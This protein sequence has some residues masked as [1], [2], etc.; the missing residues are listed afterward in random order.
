MCEGPSEGSPPACGGHPC[1]SA[2]HS[3]QVLPP[4]YPGT[5]SSINTWRPNPHVMVSFQGPSG[6]NSAPT[7]HDETSDVHGDTKPAAPEHALSGASTTCPHGVK[8][9]RAPSASE[10]TTSQ[11]PPSPTEPAGAQNIPGA[12]ESSAPPQALGGS[13]PPPKRPPRP[14]PPPNLDRTQGGVTRGA[15]HREWARR[16]PSCSLWV[17][18]T[19][20]PGAG[21]S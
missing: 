5:T 4:K 19:R 16:A 18:R 21:H 9:H 10:G 2:L 20:A 12:P 6:D 1:I 8:G 15:E 17:K 13:C 3:F 14:A 11:L 7:S